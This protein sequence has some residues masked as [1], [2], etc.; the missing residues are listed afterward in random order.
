MIRPAKVED[1]PALV[2]LGKLLHDTSSYAALDYSEEKVAATL[3]ELIRGQ[4]VVYAL[5]IDDVIRGG[6][7]GSIA[8]Y[9]FGHDVHGFDYSFF[10]HPDFRHGITA[11]R[12]LCCFEQW[13]RIKGAKTVRIGITTD[14]SVEGTTRLYQACGYRQNGRLFIKDLP[15]GN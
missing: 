15:H 9:W 2:A 5:V 3:T 4:G 10:V 13:C 14:V 8:E 7:A 6:I 12:L 11:A 1:V